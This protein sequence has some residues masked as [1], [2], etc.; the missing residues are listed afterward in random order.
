MVQ[1]AVKVAGHRFLKSLVLFVGFSLATPA[2]AQQSQPAD[3]LRLHQIQLIG[4]HNSYH[5]EPAPGLKQL[6]RV[7]GNELL[8]SIEYSHK[9]IPEQ[10]SRLGIRQL[11]LDIYADPAGG[12]FANPLGRTLA[13]ASGN[14]PGPDPNIARCLELPGFKVLHAPG[15]D[16]ATHAPSLQTALQQIRAWSESQPA[17]FPVMILLEL[18]EFAPGP[19]GVQPVPFTPEL[20]KQLHSLLESIFPRNHCLI[21]QD[22]C[23]PGDNCVRDAVLSRGWPPLKDVRGR[24]FFCLDNEGDWT[25]RWLKAMENV[26]A[27]RVFVSVSPDHPQAAWFKRN[28][29]ER[30]FEEITSLVR[31]NFLI[32]TR[33]DA[34]TRQSRSGDTRRRDQAFA[35]GAQYISTDFPV[36]DSRFTDYAVRWP[37]AAVGRRNPVS[38]PAIT[39]PNARHEWLY[40]PR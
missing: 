28:D 18:K 21:P 36:A 38:A 27:P 22:L 33:A 5:I 6:I 17:H 34:D 8:E 13:K 24:V 25:D 4:T 19:S 10:L 16:F 26:D 7:A 32:R 14:N 30:Q 37:D 35:S 23:G 20:L 12:L 40:E 11:E 2:D 9:P 39:P 31:R 3:E 15:F 29:P 1:L